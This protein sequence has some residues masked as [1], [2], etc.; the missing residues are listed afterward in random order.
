[1]QMEVLRVENSAFA[2]VT[3]CGLPWVSRDSFL[4][5]PGD[6]PPEPQTLEIV[7]SKEQVAFIQHI[8]MMIIN[9]GKIDS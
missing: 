9:D 5:S 7:S 4:S 6:S 1:M 2:V 3:G 8:Q